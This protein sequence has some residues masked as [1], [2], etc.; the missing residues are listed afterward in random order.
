MYSSFLML[1]EPGWNWQ[2]MFLSS[3]RVGWGQSYDS[4]HV[5]RCE[6]ALWEDTFQP[7]LRNALKCT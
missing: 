5:L 1:S 7:L 3:K 4:Q 6:S 2:H